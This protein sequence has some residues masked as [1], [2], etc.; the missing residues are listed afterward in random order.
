VSCPDPVH[1]DRC[2]DDPEAR[3][4]LAEHL[5]SCRACRSLGAVLEELPELL[6]QASTWAGD[7]GCLDEE[8]L[9]AALT[10][11]STP[12]HLA[13]C[14]TCRAEL[15]GLT[16]AV[17]DAP[18]VSWELE[19]GLRELPTRGE[20]RRRLQVRRGSARRRRVGTG[21]S[22]RLGGKPPGT[23][24]WAWAT[25]AAAAS[26]LVL[27]ALLLRPGP[28][29]QV[30]IAPN[31][32]DTPRATGSPAPTASAS[33]SPDLE[34]P[35]PEITPRVEPAGTPA[36]RPIPSR[37]VSPASVALDLPP[38]YDDGG[39]LQ[40]D[41]ARLGGSVERLGPDGW[42]P[43]DRATLKAGDK[44]RAGG[45]GGFLSLEE[46]RY[47]VCLAPGSVSAV[48]A[49]RDGAVLDVERGVLRAEV[50]SLLPDERFEV[51]SR[52]GRFAVLGTVFAV[53]DRG[54]EP[55]RLT[56]SE[57]TVAARGDGGTGEASAGEALTLSATDGLV[58]TAYDARALAWA[59]ALSPQR[60]ELQAVRFDSQ[61]DRGGFRGDLESKQLR[62][63]LL[64]GDPQWGVGAHS[65][66]WAQ[67]AERDV[68]L[69]LVVTSARDVTCRVELHNA[70]QN[71]QVQVE[72]ALEA[73]R[74]RTL[75]IPLLAL[76]TDYDPARHPVRPG[77]RL[78]GLRIL[79][80]GPGEA[81]VVRVDEVTVYRKV[82]R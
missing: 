41:M 9:L 6:A 54:E 46:G 49:T 36:P 18:R 33:R 26:V 21:R 72:L 55:A 27:L 59:E 10:G 25:L 20:S 39:E 19:T 58:S 60:R 74:L 68:Y 64:D 43:L 28:P 15:T 44:L 52:H 40:L 77:D 14:A 47:E 42:L 57:G 73:G 11:E 70:R 51:V 3:A 69:R 45:E 7:A 35:L 61:D 29:A 76:T 32:V 23:P 81:P 48:R 80:G 30:A 71:K 13:K 79:A 56:V 31:V 4:E 75:T 63:E 24:G 34:Y 37:D 82:Y 16:E 38:I 17:A 66:I 65:P 5:V 12:A 50:V 62:L 78:E 8:A 1:I 53:E 22:A 67:V 2:L